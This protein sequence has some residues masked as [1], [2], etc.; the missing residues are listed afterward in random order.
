MAFFLI[1]LAWGALIGGQLSIPRIRSARR[2]RY[3]QRTCEKEANEQ[4]K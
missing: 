4:E 3:A 1:L 2:S